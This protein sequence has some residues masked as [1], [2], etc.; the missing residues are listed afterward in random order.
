MSVDP[1]R[2]LGLDPGA[3]QADIKRAYR[4]LAKA[5]HPDSAG[6]SALPAF[7]AIQ[8]AY[9]SLSGDERE[10]GL[11]RGP[12]TAPG[13]GAR[14]GPG[15]ANPRSAPPR[16]PR[17]ADPVRARAAREQARARAGR[18]GTTSGAGATGPTG[19]S[20]TSDPAGTTET[21]GAGAGGRAAAGS[22]GTASGGRAR[23]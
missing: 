17:R 3:S 6:E 20:G 12:G 10:R 5:F 15:P 7:L 23:S 22:T 14:S 16:E 18:A 11:R 4:R 19:S 13:A 9:T 8:D 21:P 2:I 1:Y